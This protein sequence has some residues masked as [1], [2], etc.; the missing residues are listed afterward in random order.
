MSTSLFNKIKLTVFLICLMPA[1]ASAAGSVE[2]KVFAP[3][4]GDVAGV[5][6]RGFLVDLRA[7][8]DGDLA[9]TGASLELTGPGAHANTAP[10]PGDFGPG[11]DP[12]FPGLVVLLSSTKIGAGP[13]M[14]LANLF[15]IVAVTDRY[16]DGTD[17]SND[18]TEIWATWIVGAP[19]LFG[20]SGQLVQSR[21]FAAVVEGNAPFKVN[22]MDGDGDFDKTDLELMGHTVI[23]NVREIDFV[24]NGN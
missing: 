4:N 15:N 12:S 2:L 7:R 17:S 21:L 19:N 11:S 5:N 22:D 20:T 1:V 16:T 23:S 6:S 9:S 13:G 24:V 8:F 3:N 18:E 10:L 14:N